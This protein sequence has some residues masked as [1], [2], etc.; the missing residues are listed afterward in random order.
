MSNNVLET[1]SLFAKE[2]EIFMRKK[3]PAFNYSPLI[4]LIMILSLCLNLYFIVS[5]GGISGGDSAP[6]W[7]Q[8]KEICEPG[9]YGPS[10]IEIVEGPLKITAPGVKLQNTRVTDDLILT[11]AIGDGCVD[12]VNVFVEDRVMVQGGG[13]DTV[14]FEDAMINH[15]VINRVE[16][17][18]RVVLK[19]NTVV[20][21]V[22]ILGEAALSANA[23]SGEGRVG[24]LDIETAAEIDLDGDFETVCVTEPEAR[25]TLLA[26][27]VKSLRTGD[28]AEGAL[29][30]LKE[31]VIIDSLSAGAPLEISGAGTM[32]DILVSSPGLCK[33]SGSVEKI[34]AAGRGIFLEFG[35]AN[36]DALFVDPSEGNVMIHLP[37]GAAAEYMEF[38]GAAE[39]T[40]AGSIGHVKIN[41]SGVCIEQKPGK[42]DLARGIK[43]MVGGEEL[44]DDKTASKATDKD[45]D[46]TGKGQQPKKEDPAPAPTTPP[47]NP[48]PPPPEQPKTPS[49]VVTIVNSQLPGKKTV[50]VE[51]SCSDPQN[52]NVSVSGVPLPYNS[53][54]GYFYADVAEEIAQESNVKVTRQ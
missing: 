42:V 17:K 26:G 53:K 6:G 52:Y 50:I 27:E 47:S 30:D 2:R 20:N 16:G 48:E 46:S 43:A 39:V 44:P 7:Q 45:K 13:E 40:G 38:N 24:E 35:A 18:V 11:A 29:I 22:T 12:L 8:L 25:V 1:I 41:V 31:G 21:K 19:G 36:I 37:E 33:I 4:Y 23:L 14:V 5:P 28:E 9:T 10:D 49:A 15:L 51:L 34:S 32:K 3:Q 54:L